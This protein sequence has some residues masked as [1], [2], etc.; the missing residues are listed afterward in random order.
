MESVKIIANLTNNMKSKVA[1]SFVGQVPT[2]MK[3]LTTVQL[4]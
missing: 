3:G 1:K 2:R 4:S